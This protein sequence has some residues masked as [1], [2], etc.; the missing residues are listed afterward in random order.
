MLRTAGPE[1]FSQNG[2][3]AGI[4]DLKVDGI[5]DVIEEGLE[6]GVAVSFRGLLGALGEP[7]QK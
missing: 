6:A 2:R 5:S 7:S 3:V 1:Y 4:L